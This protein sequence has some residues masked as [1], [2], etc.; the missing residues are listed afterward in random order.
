M[1]RSLLPPAACALLSSVP[2]LSSAALALPANAAA[3]AMSEPCS[4]SSVAACVMRSPEESCT[5]GSGA[6][7]YVSEAQRCPSVVPHAPP[8]APFFQGAKHDAP[9]TQGAATLDSNKP[10]VV[11]CDMRANNAMKHLQHVRHAQVG[12]QRVARQRH[13]LRKHCCQR[14]LAVQ[15]DRGSCSRAGNET[16][17][18]GQ[19]K[20]SMHSPDNTLAMQHD[21]TSC[22]RTTAE[23]SVGGENGEGCALQTYG[24]SP[25]TKAM[26]E[27]M[28]ARG[29]VISMQPAC[30]PPHLRPLTQLLLIS[31][32]YLG[33]LHHEA[34]HP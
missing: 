16:G 24:W 10:R 22:A 14:L 31:R 6:S 25:P 5:Q 29:R 15:Q 32:L 21:R 30:L 19:G 3:G 12:P 18:G 8:A 26:Q 28:R 4:S 33:T 23:L 2:M 11:I 17:Q 1:T 13:T 9:S 34:L 20:G 27:S 7:G